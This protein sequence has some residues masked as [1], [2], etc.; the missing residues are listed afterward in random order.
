MTRPSR[1]RS[2][3]TTRLKQAAPDVKLAQYTRPDAVLDLSAGSKEELLRAL[4]NVVVP[5]AGEDVVQ[6][7]LRSI[8]ER[9]AAVNTYVGSG[10][11][12]PHARVDCVEGISI[13]IA[14]NPQGLPYGI[15]TDEPVV[16]AVL[17][18]GNEN[19]KSEHVHLLGA[20]ARLLVNPELKDQ[21]LHASDAAAVIRLLDSRRSDRLRGKA[22]PLT[23][24]LLSYAKKIARET[25]VSSIVVNIETREELEILTIRYDEL[26]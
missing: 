20:I 25:G 17:V 16:L 10:V 4:A 12:I 15:D 26:P 7:I 1:E 14:R 23:Q 18:V 5:G 2:T 13:A 6:K 8:E 11:A 3:T 19:L 24:L 22:R 21:I 9:E